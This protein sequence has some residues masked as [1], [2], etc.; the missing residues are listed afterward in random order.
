VAETTD[1]TGAECTSAQVRQFSGLATFRLSNSTT[2][3][4]SSCGKKTKWRRLCVRR[5]DIRRG[6]RA[7]RWPDGSMH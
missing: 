7:W 1:G 2:S 4:C 5:V 6:Q 3:C